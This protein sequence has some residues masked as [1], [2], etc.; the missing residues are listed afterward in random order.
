MQV[1]PRNQA[2][3]SGR[4]HSADRHQSGPKALHKKQAKPDQDRKPAKAKGQL[5]QSRFPSE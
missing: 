2:A 3:L 1:V 5:G 4:A